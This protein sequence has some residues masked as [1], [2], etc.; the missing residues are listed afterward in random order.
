MQDSMIRIHP[1]TAADQD[2]L[3]AALYWAIHVPPGEARPPREIVRQPEL[4]HY[5]AGW[6]A[7]PGDYGVGAFADEGDDP[8]LLWSG[9]AAK[10]LPGRAG[11]RLRKQY[12][13]RAFHCRG[14]RTIVAGAW[15][16]GC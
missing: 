3:W 7:R 10:V 13:P 11:L 9:L 1:L 14:G 2:L 8:A 16:R 12:D 4:A 15:A 5:A 6:G